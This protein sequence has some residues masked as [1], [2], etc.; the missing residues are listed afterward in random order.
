VPYEIKFIILSQ[1]DFFL[2]LSFYN[3]CR[4]LDLKNGCYCWLIVIQIYMD[5]GIGAMCEG[6]N[7]FYLVNKESTVDSIRKN[8]FTVS[9]YRMAFETARVMKTETSKLKNIISASFK[10]LSLTIPIGDGFHE[11]FPFSHCHL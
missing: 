6:G 2:G 10:P 4:R 11:S 3:D 9:Q 7:C 8:H 1:S 5:I